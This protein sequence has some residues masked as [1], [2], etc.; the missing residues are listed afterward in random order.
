MIDNHPNQKHLKFFE[1]FSFEQGPVM[2]VKDLG[3][4]SFSELFNAMGDAAQETIKDLFCNGPHKS[5]HLSY[6]NAYKLVLSLRSR[7]MLK[8]YP[9][10]LGTKKVLY[11]DVAYF[12]PAKLVKTANEKYLCFPERVHKPL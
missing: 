7:T 10:T 4:D 1:Q 11:V 8:I 5:E 9:D 12:N 3:Q 6:L 2:I